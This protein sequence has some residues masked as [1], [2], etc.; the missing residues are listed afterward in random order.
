MAHPEPR[1]PALIPARG[2]SRGIPG[3]NLAEVGGVPL[4]TRCVRA[5]LAA[6]RLSRVAVST[7]C[8]QIAA[9]A[10]AAGAEVPGLRPAE[11]ALDDTPIDAVLRHVWPSLRGEAAGLVLLQP[12]S[13]FLRPETI[14]RA[15]EE[16]LRRGAPVLK[17]VR[18]V[19]EHPRWMLRRRGDMLVMYLDDEGPV[20]R[21]ELSGLFIPCGAVYVYSAEYLERPDP[22]APSSWVDVGWPECLDIDEPEDLEIARMLARSAE[23]DGCDRDPAGST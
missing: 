23:R 2:R 17:A 4:V 19:R 22:A 21:Q 3:K 5:A 15:V 1:L 6:T 10:R 11:L 12:T 13:P 18:R 8:E 16:F 14:D 7:D 9:V 20:R